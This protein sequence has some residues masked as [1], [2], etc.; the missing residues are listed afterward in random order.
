M[1]L[2]S[3]LARADV[4]RAGQLPCAEPALATGFDA[5]DAELPGGGWPV[6]S[7]VE[8]LAPQG[9]G[10]LRLLLPALA[11]LSRCEDRWICWVAPPWL[12]C[13]TALQAAGVD[14]SRLLLVHPKARQDGLWAVEQSLRSGTCSAVLAW[15]A[16]DDTRWLRRL[17]LAAVAGEAL[18]VL[19]RSPACAAS[20]SPAALRLQLHP[21]RG[22]KLAVSILKRRGGPSGRSLQLD[23]PQHERALAVRAATPPGAGYFPPYWQ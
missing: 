3:L 20:P 6:A 4:W 22:R 16:L 11:R 9:R 14:I 10:A 1:S 15:P 8:V 13:A 18:G 17:Q 5:L 23:F 12:P 7:L 21:R 2:E 19:F